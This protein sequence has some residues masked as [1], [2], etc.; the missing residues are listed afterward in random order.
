M[1][2]NIEIKQHIVIDNGTGFCK[3]GFSGEKIPKIIIP[4]LVG[5]PKYASG[6]V[7]VDKKQFFVGSEAEAIKGVLNINNPIEHGVV[8]NWDD[9][10]KIWK[11]IFSNGLKVDPV[12]YNIMLTETPMNPKENR[13]KMTQIMFES[14]NA[15]GL[16]IASEPVLS[17]YS[18][19]KYSGISADF[20]THISYFVPI[21]F[22]CPIPLAVYRLNFAGKDLTEYMMRLLDEN[23]QRF[24]TTAEKEIIN[25]IKEKS[26]YVALD[27]EEEL[28]NIR[29]FN[30]ELPDGNKIAL[31][32][33]RIKCPEILFKPNIIGK[34]VDGIGKTCYDSVQ[35]CNPDIRKDLYNNIVLSGGTSMFRGLQERFSKEIKNFITDSMK[36]EVN[37][38]A[39]D[40]RKFA[41]WTGGSILSK[42][43]SDS[44]WITKEEYEEYGDLIVHR[45]CS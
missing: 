24:S 15:K 32:E 44:I 17:L 23:G 7:G 26:C 12:E 22:G 6:R 34:E 45:K 42:S 28:K 14:F 31:K 43:F 3:A 37:V 2:E 19:G 39:S 29:E 18:L 30:Y 10:E 1:T 41:V 5:Y 25:N 13:E 11:F 33:E 4:S 8:N 16:Y 35:K 20:G 27:Y 38:N 21:F 40:E 36:E 9:I